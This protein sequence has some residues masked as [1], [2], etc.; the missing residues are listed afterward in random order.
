LHLQQEGPSTCIK[1]ARSHPQVEHLYNLVY[2]VLDML[3]TKKYGALS[4]RITTSFILSRQQL[5]KV[6]MVRDAH[7]DETEDFNTRELS[8]GT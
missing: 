4:H 8:V 1:D 2:E 5:Q 3:A 6:S 7:E